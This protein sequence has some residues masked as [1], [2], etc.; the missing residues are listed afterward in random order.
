MDSPSEQKKFLQEAL[1][2]VDGDR[3]G[4]YGHPAANFQRI[5]MLWSVALGHPITLK[6]V[7]LMMV[8]LKVSREIH[9]PGRDNL[10]DIAGYIQCID[11]MTRYGSN[12]EA[13]I[14]V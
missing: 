2:I 6:Q 12:V 9:K 8:L 4:T 5:A 14:G 7:A 10:V 13:P 3:E 1:D 11:K